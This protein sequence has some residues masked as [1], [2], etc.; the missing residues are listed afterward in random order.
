VIARI[1]RRQNSPFEV[2]LLDDNRSAL[3]QVDCLVRRRILFL[4]HRV[5]FPPNRGDR[6]RSYHL[7]KFLSAQVEV[8]LACLADEPVPESSRRE[9]A[10]LCRRVAVVPLMSSLRWFKA[11]GSLIQGRSATEGLFWS[12]NFAD[13]LQRWTTDT[14]YD[15]VLAY[16]SS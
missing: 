11:L 16:C 6:I 10:S 9:L 8:D 15:L 14:Q 13:I 3:H 1:H 12:R 7:L 2:Q 4:T 5:P